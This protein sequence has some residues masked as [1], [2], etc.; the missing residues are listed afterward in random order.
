MG[1]GLVLG[2]GDDVVHILLAE[3]VGQLTGSLDLNA[4]CEGGDG[5][6]GLVFVLMEGAVHTGCAL[7]LHTVDLDL[8]LEAL[9]GEG[10]AGDESAAAH[11]HDNGIHIGQLVENFEA[12]GTLTGND[13]LVVVGVYEGHARLFL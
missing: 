10:H 6:K 7:G 12:D 5:R 3:L 8:R 9:D 4:V 2:D 13:L 11:R 1:S